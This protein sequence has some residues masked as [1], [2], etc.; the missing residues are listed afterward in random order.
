MTRL[1]LTLSK[2]LYLNFMGKVLG[3]FSFIWKLYVAII[4]VILALIY[5]PIIYP[6]LFSLKN[7]K[8]AFKVFVFWSWS[9][10]VLCFYHVKKVKKSEL[11]K[12]PF[13][14]A[15][16]HISYL[17][18][19][20]LYSILPKDEFLFLGKGELLNYPIIRHY[21]KHLNIPVHRGSAIKSARSLVKAK[22]EVKNGWSLVIFPEGRIPD[23]NPKQIGYKTG[24]FQL[25]KEL[26]LPI[27]PMTY[28]NNHLLFSDPSD[29]L[30]RAHPGIS[31]VYIHDYISSEDVEA[32]DK[33]ALKNRCFDIINEPLLQ[34]YPD[35]NGKY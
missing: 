16:N 30:G 3:V 2:F 19:F 7:K 33:N 17:D 27:L 11:P 12:G 21:F 26:H 10:R 31:R 15:A 14:I 5:L 22:Q 13:I 28:T 18:I 32:L 1:T 29:I 9:V 25:A 24:A 6:L 20:L 23:L 8:R 35:L 4:F 34:E